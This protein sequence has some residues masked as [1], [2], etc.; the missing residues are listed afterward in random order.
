MAKSPRIIYTPTKIERELLAKIES[1]LGL[2]QA[3]IHRSAIRVFAEHLFK[4]PISEI[5]EKARV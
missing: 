3:Q 1:E 4:K 2:K 5:I